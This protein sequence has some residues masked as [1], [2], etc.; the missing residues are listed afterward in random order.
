[1]AAVAVVIMC[2]GSLIPVATFICPVVCIGIT[3][4]VYRACGARITW[5]WYG[6]VAILSLLLGPDKEAAFLFLFLG[7]YPCIK[8]W[9][10][11]SKLA[12]VWKFLYF[13]CTIALA[14]FLMIGLFQLVDVINDYAFTG[15][16]M[17]IAMFALGNVVFFLLDQLLVVKL[18][19]KRRKKPQEEKTE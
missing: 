7:Y 6:A 10:E 1:M 12:V 13:N 18:V 19:R 4:I 9:M 2:M 11:K 15:T 8:T 14:Y 17:T 16:V 5:A 3:S